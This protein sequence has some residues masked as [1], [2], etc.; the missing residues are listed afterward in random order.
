MSVIIQQERTSQE[1]VK[2]VTAQYLPEIKYIGDLSAVDNS[3]IRKEVLR[4]WIVKSQRKSR[5]VA[6]RAIEVLQ[7]TVEHCTGLEQLRVVG[8]EVYNRLRY[9]TS[10]YSDVGRPKE[11]VEYIDWKHPEQNIYELAEEVTVPSNGVHTGHRRPDLVLYV[12]GIALV[13]MELKR[14]SVSAKEGIRQSYRNQQTGEIPRFFSTVQLVLA[15]NSSEGL[16][17]GTTATEEKYFLRWKEPTGVSDDLK[18]QFPMYSEVK[19]DLLRGWLQMVTPWRLLEVI[20]DLII[21]DSG[22]KKICR[23]NQY[24]ALKAVQ[25]RI[26]HGRESGIIW[27]SQGSGKSLLMIFLARWIRENV[28]NSRVVI[29]TDRDELDQ[30]ITLGLRKSGQVPADY[31]EAA[32]HATSGND[33]L[34][35][36][37]SPSPW[38]ITTLIHKFASSVVRD[39]KEERGELEKKLKRTPEQWMEDVGQH[40]QELFGDGFEPKG[41]FF[42]FVDECHR[43]QGGILHEAMKHI[44]GDRVML[45]GFTGTPL[46]TGKDKKRISSQESFGRYIHSYRFDEAVTDGVVLD[47]RYEAR[48]V[49]QNLRNDERLEREFDLKTRDLTPKAKERLKQRWA[50]LKHIYSSAE[51]I[52]RI[53]GDILYDM[54]AQPAL[55]EGYGNAMLVCDSIYECYKY[56]EVFNRCDFG[57]SCAVITSYDPHLGLSNAYSGGRKTEEEYKYARAMEMLAGRPTEEFET[58]AKKKFVEEPSAM[59]LLIVC[60]KLLTGFDAPSATYLY[61]DRQL[62][63]HTLFQAIC[64]VNRVNGRQKDYGYIID[65]K[66]LFGFIEQAISDY[67]NGETTMEGFEK[68]EIHQLMKGRVD[69][70]RKE[71]DDALRAEK[72]LLSRISPQG[73]QAEYFA[74][75]CE[76]PDTEID[77]QER[78]DYTTRRDEFYTITYRLVRRYSDIAMDMSDAGYS[79]KEREEIHKEVLD[80]YN[81]LKAIQLRSGDYVDMTRYDADMRFLL[82]QYIDADSS[83][84]LE[85]MDDF[86]FLDIIEK[87]EE[88]Y[89]VDPEK[90]AALGGDEGVAETMVANTRRVIK[91]EQNRNPEEYRRLSDRLDRLLRE[92]KEKTIEYQAFLREILE[93]N[94]LFSEPHRD[95]IKEYSTADNE[96]KRAFFDNFGQ[97]PELAQKLHETAL[98][99]TSPG[100]ENNLSFQD[101]LRRELKTVLG[102]DE[103][104]VERAYQICLARQ[105]EINRINDHNED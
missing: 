10:V 62:V 61:M 14:S 91:R 43:S 45:I 27:H 102:G 53:V 4:D 63:D 60:D 52:E 56:W 33:L 83:E 87:R 42:V 76:D 2:A 20:H 75:F 80:D 3:N 50:S 30:Q 29:I 67:T 37:N 38:I 34:Q 68:E 5:Q 58:W 28:D 11:R 26:L 40:I 73:L 64:R 23:P 103:S 22:I 1:A 7:T 12:N 96:V 8:E 9:G 74:Y 100:I 99:Y 86:S 48:D 79:V 46:L 54:E 17:Y 82:D 24:F 31:Q 39:A 36:L 32:F 98:T 77:E 6:D 88:S 92:M 81:L 44:M 72:A 66:Q 19:D 94:N 13:V 89:T 85:K 35:K 47:L 65:Y 84:L 95:A 18:D 105:D 69:Q 93:I 15:G 97:D 49:P 41:E 104:L 55:R 90:R 25:Q 51:R 101:N 70:A 59:K 21:Y 16:Y 78:I 57:Q 71:L